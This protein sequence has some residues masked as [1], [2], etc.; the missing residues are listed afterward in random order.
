MSK[1]GRGRRAQSTSVVRRGGPDRLRHDRAIASFHSPEIGDARAVREEHRRQV[2]VRRVAERDPL[3][4]RDRADDDLRATVGERGERDA[5]AVGREARRQLE[6]DFRRKRLRARKLALEVAR[7]GGH[8]R[9]RPEHEHRRERDRG[10]ARGRDDP[11]GRSPARLRGRA[12]R[13][14]R[15]GSRRGRIGGRAGGWR[16]VHGDPAGRRQSRHGRDQ[17]VADLG[18][19]LDELR[20]ARV[21]AQRDAQVG[22]HPRQHLVVDD[23]PR[24]DFVEQRLPANRLAVG[25]G[26]AQQHVHHARLDADGRSRDDQFVRRRTHFDVGE[27]ER[28]LAAPRRR[29]RAGQHD[30]R[31]IKG[32]MSGGRKG[33]KNGEGNQDA[34]RGSAAVFAPVLHPPQR[35]PS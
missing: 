24:P 6:R 20:V 13:R 14:M 28:R 12:C 21:V 11:A 25:G 5:R 34:G 7:D 33:R 31:R 9:R 27:R 2:R 18:N 10:G 30:L 17:P 29:R 23:P 8:G 26:E 1:S 3:R 15:R 22:D 35:G 19:R 32:L 4:A 16:R